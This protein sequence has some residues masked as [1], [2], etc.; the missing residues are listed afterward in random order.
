MADIDDDVV[1]FGKRTL[2]EVRERDRIRDAAITSYGITH[3]VKW[4]CDFRKEL[5]SDEELKQLAKNLDLQ[6]RLNLAD[7]LRGGRVCAVKLNARVKPGE[8]GHYMDYCSLYPSIQKGSKYPTG[9]PSVLVGEDIQKDLS[10]YFGIAKVR[11]CPPRGLF[12][13]VLPVK[14]NGKLVFTLCSSCADRMQQT[15]CE[16]SDDDRSWV[17]TYCTPE[18]LHAAKR[19]YTF[20]K[21]YEVYHWPTSSQYD[22]A[23]KTGGLFNGYFEMFM[24]IKQEASGFPDW[25]ADEHDKIKYVSDYLEH[26]GIL[27]DINNIAPNPTMRSIAK[28]CNNTLWG[29]FGQRT[30]H[31]SVTLFRSDQLD[32]FLKFMADQTREITD[33]HIWSTDLISVEWRYK[34][35]SM[36]K[37]GFQQN[38]VLAAFTTCN[39]RLKL[40]SALEQIKE[41]KLLYYDTGEWGRGWGC[42]LMSTS[43]TLK[44]NKNTRDV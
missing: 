8:R 17:G 4:E 28:L 21:I 22:P 43:T 11:V 42:L 3:I 10:Q 41:D 15:P 30:D 14:C 35:P 32:Q 5:E 38:V 23:T 39:A 24:K 18:L 29:K 12:L 25:V 7:S 33:F 13:P 31:S 36:E 16:C 1:L 2:K 34:Y 40:L 20:P 44:K 9:V 19:G 27:L 37:P 6:P 26:E